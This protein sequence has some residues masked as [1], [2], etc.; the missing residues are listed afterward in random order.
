MYSHDKFY[1]VLKDK[2]GVKF[3]TFAAADRS[4]S[5]V[6]NSYQLIVNYPMMY[7]DSVYLPFIYKNINIEIVRWTYC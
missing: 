1:W 3:P 7:Q 5:I 6:K 4:D 2:W